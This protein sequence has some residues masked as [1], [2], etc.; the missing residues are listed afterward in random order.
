MRNGAIEVLAGTQQFQ[1]QFDHGF[2]IRPRHQ[3]RGRQLQ[4]QAPK[5]L[6]ADNARDRLAREAAACEVV[7]A[8]R[9]VRGELALR[10][11]YQAGQIEAERVAGQNPRVEVGGFDRGGFESRGECAPRGFDGLSAKSVT[12]RTA[13]SMSS[14]RTQG[15]IRRRPVDCG[16]VV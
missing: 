3:R 15:P 13:I 5:F 11:R 16:G 12:R 1:R 14:L 4:R 7:E 8:S 2:G 6:L 9:F 10:G